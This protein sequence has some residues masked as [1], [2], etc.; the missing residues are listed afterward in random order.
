[1]KPHD[2]PSS[3]DASSRSA[4]FAEAVAYLEKRINYENFQELPYQELEGRLARMRHLLSVLGN[5][6]KKYLTVHVAGTKGKGSTCV[7]LKSILRQ[8]GYRVGFFSSPHLDTMTERFAIDGVPCSDDEFADVMLSLRDRI[9]PWEQDNRF[10]YFELT[11]LF[12]F[13]FFARKNVD[14]AVVEVGM[15]GRLDATNA[16]SPQLTIITSI[17]FDHIEQLG[18]SLVQIA[19][20]KAGIIKPEIPVIAHPGDGEAIEIVRKTA[21][22]FQSPSFFYG[23]D[24][25][26]ESDPSLTTAFRYLPIGRENPAFVP[27]DTLSLGL[28]GDHQ[29]QNASLAIAAA[30]LLRPRLTIADDAIRKGLAEAFLPIRIEAIR[31]HKDSATF[32]VDGAH[33]RA[34]VAAL[35]QTL[36]QSF[37]ARKKFLVFGTT[38]GK[39]VDG[40]LSELQPFFDK[41]VLT[42]HSSSPRRFPSRGLLT[43]LSSL[44]TAPLSLQNEFRFDSPSDFEGNPM[45]DDIAVPLFQR[46]WDEFEEAGTTHADTEIDVIESSFEALK[47]CWAEAEKDDLVCVTG[48]MYLAG[49][50]RR[51]FLDELA[52]SRRPGNR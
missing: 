11:T 35:V 38:L 31:P 13:E 1:M 26:I 37:P 39:D 43:I 52:S 7:M 15:G 41:I 18:P 33:N 14:V 45:D 34:S 46:R 24:F 40:M 48:S 42:Q 30:M 17:S 21:A 3:S 12:A 8:A 23:E 6:E 36:K 32:I 27:L 50:L 20:E 16:C 4:K 44:P 22:M 2:S 49:E 51:Y 29:R 25:S 9:E 47:K 28:P 10:T 19:S 5:P